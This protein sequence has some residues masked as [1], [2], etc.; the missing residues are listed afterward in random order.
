VKRLNRPSNSVTIKFC[1]EHVGRIS[2]ETRVESGTSRR[3]GGRVV[4]K[5][6][7]RSAHKRTLEHLM[8]CSLAIVIPQHTAEPLATKN[9]A[10]TSVDFLPRFDY[11]ISETLVITFRV[12]MVQE[13]TD[14]VS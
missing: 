6:P 3:P 8:S 11:S 10:A 4:C 14:G 7:M 1:I 5:A 13:R 2:V 12:E 9:F